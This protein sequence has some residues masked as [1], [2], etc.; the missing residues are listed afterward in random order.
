[1]VHEAAPI[2]LGGQHKVIGLYGHQEGRQC[3]QAAA[4]PGVAGRPAGAVALGWAKGIDLTECQVGVH[5]PGVG[6]GV[7]KFPV[8]PWILGGQVNI[9]FRRGHAVGRWVRSLPL[10][11]NGPDRVDVLLDR[12]EV[13]FPE[14]VPPADVDRHQIVWNDP[15]RKEDTDL[16]LGFPNHQGADALK[17]VLGGGRPDLDPGVVRFPNQGA[18][19]FPHARIRHVGYV[20]WYLYWYPQCFVPIGGIGSELGW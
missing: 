19:V 18:P 11:E 15:V 13:H 1:M 10:G 12:R 6:F 2:A 20:R 14:L 4:S 3:H 7:H 9:D 8:C 16:P 5:G 17:E